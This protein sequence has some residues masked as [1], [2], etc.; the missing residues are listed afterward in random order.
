M[1][2]ALTVPSADEEHKISGELASGK[3]M[4]EMVLV[5]PRQSPRYC[6]V[7][8]PYNLIAFVE[9]ETA[10]VELSPLHTPSQQKVKKSHPVHAQKNIFQKHKP[11]IN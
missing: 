2:Q 1:S 9:S 5:C 4:S 10:I 11:R 6:P 3:E 8:G 7:A